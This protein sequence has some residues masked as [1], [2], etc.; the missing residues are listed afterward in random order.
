[1]KLNEFGWPEKKKNYTSPKVLYCKRVFFYPKILWR[2]FFLCIDLSNFRTLKQWYCDQYLESFTIIKFLKFKFLRVPKEVFFTFIK[3]NLKFFE[4]KHIFLKDTDIVLFGPYMNNHTHKIIDFLI[5][6]PI[7]KKKKYKRV[8]APSELKN[9]FDQTKASTFLDKKIVYFD[10]YK[11]I[12]FEN[13]NYLPHVDTRTSNLVYKNAANQYRNFLKKK[14]K[15]NSNYKYILVSRSAGKRRLLNENILYNA[16]KI[17]GFKRVFFEKMTYKKQFEISSNA[18]IIIGYH[19]AGLSN[20]FFMKKNHHLL[21][22][23]NQSYNHP[24]FKIYTS[25]LQLK[26]KKFICTKNLSNLNGECD[27]IE[28]VKY[29]RNI[30]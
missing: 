8:F 14:F 23:V 16:I 19:G 4:K 26:Y 6:L 9:L 7:L 25:V 15:K 28:I 27:S 17:Y 10:S 21:E 24:F 29:I 3:F 30:L 1:M 18:K 22:I 11:K 2:N 5:R 12:I 13:V 20:A